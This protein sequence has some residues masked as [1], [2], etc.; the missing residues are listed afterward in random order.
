MNYSSLFLLCKNE[1]KFLEETIRYYLSI[2]IDKIYF[3]DNNID[4]EQKN[5]I[6]RINNNKI[7]YF[8]YKLLLNNDFCLQNEYI[9]NFKKDSEW[10]LFFDRDEI[11]NLE[12][13][14]SINEMLEKYEQYDCLFFNWKTFAEPYSNVKN[15]NNN[16]ILNCTKREKIQSN[17]TMSHHVKF[18]AKNRFINLIQ[19]PHY[20]LISSKKLYN[21]TLQTECQPEP[22]MEFSNDSVYK[23]PSLHH[24]FY[25]GVE[26]FKLKMLKPDRNEN[27][28]K[29][30]RYDYN[31]WYKKSHILHFGDKYEYVQ[32]T[33]LINFIN[34]EKLYDKIYPTKTN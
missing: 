6:D 26:N 5:I 21:V 24:Y 27:L 4:D 20:P 1:Q 31:L 25:N 16:L 8:K 18:I 10:T 2:G 28:L 11:L 3:F 14:S 30:C 9:T 34:R 17:F 12:Q 29:E 32:D 22:K 19:N 33:S 13:H 15:I 7:A 23:N